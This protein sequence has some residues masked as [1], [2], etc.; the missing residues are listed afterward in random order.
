MN[1][2]SFSHIHIYTHTHFLLIH[3]STYVHM[4][5]TYTCVCGMQAHT[6]HTLPTELLLHR[7][8]III[9]LFLFVFAFDIKLY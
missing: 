7:C 2:V 3:T 4:H 8:T 6:T 5:T 1:R 9:S